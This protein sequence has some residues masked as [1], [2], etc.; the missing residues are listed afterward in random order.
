METKTATEVIIIGA[1]PTGLSLACQ[2]CRFW[3][4]DCS[5]PFGPFDPSR[6]ARLGSCP[7]P[8]M[9]LQ[10]FRNTGSDE[11]NHPGNRLPGTLIDGSS[12]LDT[13]ILYLSCW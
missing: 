7:W 2:F 12:L 4:F 9:G 11:R 1:G 13:S 3:R 5:H 8:S 10:H 6:P